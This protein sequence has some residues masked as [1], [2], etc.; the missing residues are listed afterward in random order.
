MFIKPRG[1]GKGVPFPVRQWEYYNGDPLHLINSEP[2][3]FYFN[4]SKV[5]LPGGVFPEKPKQQKGVLMTEEQLK[6]KGFIP[7][8]TISGIAIWRY[9]GRITCPLYCTRCG[10]LFRCQNEI[11]LHIYTHT[12]ERP[13]KCEHCSYAFASKSNLRRHTCLK[14]DNVTTE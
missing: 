6:L 10:K 12:G 13:Y 14:V 7:E 9:G 11:R 3:A 2:E 1:G 8:I 4:R 5:T